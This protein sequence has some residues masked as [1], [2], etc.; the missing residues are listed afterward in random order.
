MELSSSELEYL[1]WLINSHNWF[2]LR[3]FSD[4]MIRAAG[5]GVMKKWGAAVDR[6]EAYFTQ[7]TRCAPWP[8]EWPAER[9]NDHRYRLAH[10]IRQ[11]GNV[12]PLLEDIKKA[13]SGSGIP[14]SK[15]QNP[16]SKIP[17]SLL[18]FLVTRKG[19]LS[20]RWELLLIAKR[21]ADWEAF[22]SEEQAALKNLPA[23]P[24]SDALKS[25]IQ[26]SAFRT[27]NSAFRNPVDQLWITAAI[28]NYRNALKRNDAA[29]AQNIFRKLQ[30][31]G[32]EGDLLIPAKA[33]IQDP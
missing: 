4:R 31:F 17:Y 23:G 7:Q 5:L 14:Q 2:G 15:I 8:P 21:N 9:V 3:A 13:C 32:V 11:F 29:E 27:P 12:A 16:K 30:S 6:L 10:I 24:V 22:K 33:G 19:H 1:A 20:S 18:Y 26:N 28:I 25:I